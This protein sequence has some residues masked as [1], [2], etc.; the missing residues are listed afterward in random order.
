MVKKKKKKKPQFDKI[1]K[2][3]WKKKKILLFYKRN[4]KERPMIKK[5]SH[6]FRNERKH[7]EKKKGKWTEPKTQHGH[8]EGKGIF[9]NLSS[10]PL[11]SAIFSPIVTPIWRYLFDS[12]KRK[13][14]RSHQNS[15]YF[16]PLQNNPTNYFLS[17]SLFYF[18]S[19]PTFHYNQTDS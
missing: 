7:V 13:M 12:T 9:S 6:C 15:F 1:K 3:C 17:Y 14:H 16:S 19:S 5:K 8:S 10:T 2:I 11:L 4:K 18:S